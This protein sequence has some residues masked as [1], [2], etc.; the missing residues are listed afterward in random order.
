MPADAMAGFKHL[1]LM[2]SPGAEQV[3]LETGIGPFAR[4]FVH[5]GSRGHGIHQIDR[6]PSR[7][8]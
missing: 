4:S 1:P 8:P 7:A 2:L 6:P 5:F 3:G